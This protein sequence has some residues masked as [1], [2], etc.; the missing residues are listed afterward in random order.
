MQCDPALLLCRSFS[1]L[2][3]GPEG[4][5]SPVEHGESVRTYIRLSIRPSVHPS[6]GPSIGPSVRTSVGPSITPSHFRRFRRASEHRVA[7]IGSCFLFFRFQFLILLL[8]CLCC[9][10][11]CK[12]GIGNKRVSEWASE[13]AYECSGAKQAVQSTQM[14]E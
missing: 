2:G 12:H 10:H 5:R 13:Q 3:F 7:S 11:K 6:V 4:G 8:D 1:F 9:K 14:S